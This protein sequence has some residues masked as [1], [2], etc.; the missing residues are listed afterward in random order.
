M[1]DGTVVSDG[2]GVKGIDD[3]V[4]RGARFIGGEDAERQGV[5]GAPDIRL[6]SGFG[7]GEKPPGAGWVGEDLSEVTC[8]GEGGVGGGRVDVEARQ[9]AGGAVA[10]ERG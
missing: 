3:G 4:S 7:G 9:L 5:E 6:S 1:A 8:H 10:K 2:A